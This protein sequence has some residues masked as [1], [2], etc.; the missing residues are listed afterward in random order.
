MSGNQ[1]QDSRGKQQYKM[2]M[3][4]QEEG[5]LEDTVKW[6][7]KSVKN[8]NVDAHLDL[9]LVLQNGTGIPQDEKRAVS[10][11]M[12]ASKNGSR[13]A[14]YNLGTCYQEGS[15]VPQSDIKAFENFNVCALV[16]STEESEKFDYDAI[17]EKGLYLIKGI[18]GHLDQNPKD[19][20]HCLRRAAKFGRRS[21]SMYVLGKAQLDGQDVHTYQSDIR[22]EK[23]WMWIK[24]AAGKGHTAAQFMYALWRKNDHDEFTETVFNM[25]KKAADKGHI[26]AQFE[27]TQWYIEDGDLGIARDMLR[28]S[29]IKGMEN[30]DS[31]EKWIKEITTTVQTMQTRVL[32]ETKNKL[33]S[34]N[35]GLKDSL[36]KLRMVRKRKLEVDVELI[37]ARKKAKISKENCDIAQAEIHN[38]HEAKQWSICM[39]SDKNAAFVPCG[40]TFCFDDAMTHIGECFLC[41]TPVTSVIKLF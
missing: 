37:E 8:G 17:H 38:L 19:G 3:M 10:L 14:Y 34:A 21:E 36:T 13:T 32:D 2:A 30:Q 41:R 20:F 1:D 35:D 6:L 7:E 33:K 27:V 24:T 11:F 40:H 28:E 39:D 23:G 4:C 18:P 22:S 31:A 26:M 9:G 5:E 29:M 15:G 12:T 16:K 25:L